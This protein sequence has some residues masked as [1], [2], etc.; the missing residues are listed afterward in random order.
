MLR[1]FDVYCPKVLAG[2]GSFLSD[3]TL[4]RCIVVK[5]RR[6]LAE[7]TAERFRL[8]QVRP[9]TQ[10]LRDRLAVWESPAR[11]ALSGAAPGLPDALDDRAQDI[12]EPLLALA[13]LA[14]EDIGERT[15]R[16]AVELSGR[17]E[18]TDS[19][20]TL[21]LRCFWELF[22]ATD[23]DTG[24]LIFPDGRISSADAALALTNREDWPW[25]MLFP[26]DT[27]RQK[28]ALAD[29][30]R[31]FEI[32]PT[33]MKVDGAKV[34][35]YKRSMFADV[36]RRHGVADGSGEPPGTAGTPGTSQLSG[37]APPIP[38]P[39]PGIRLD[40]SVPGRVP[41]SQRSDQ[42]STRGTG[43]HGDMRI[44]VCQQCRHECHAFTDLTGRQCDAQ[45]GC[46][47]TYSPAQ[48]TDATSVTVTDMAA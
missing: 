33:Q 2:I 27:Q 23:M 42:H 31:P 22:T 40:P 46:P 12:W 25:A 10:A 24:E 41:A 5:L 44:Y 32:E 20:G 34:R 9:A 28:C 36:W 43:G 8:S 35:G 38:V 17:A 13:D 37:G 4:D 11:A 7:D 16:A 18:S 1:E 48:V 39:V 30:L 19:D 45:T 15:R 14:G 3:T 26:T 29:L 6:K 47:G 21:L